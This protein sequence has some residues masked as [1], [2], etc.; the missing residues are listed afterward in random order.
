[1]ELPRSASRKFEPVCPSQLPGVHRPD[2]PSLRRSCGGFLCLLARP[3]GQ[4]SSPRVQ[5]DVPHA[6][7]DLSALLGMEREHL[8]CHTTPLSWLGAK[9][10]AA[11]ATE[12]QRYDLALL[13]LR[14]FT[15]FLRTMELL[16]LRLSHV[17]LFPN[18]GTFVIAII[19]SRTSKGLQQPKILQFL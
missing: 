3:T 10:L 16:S 14:G 17:R 11:A 4:A 8:P 19:N 12:V 18:Q 7:S 2:L 13:V 15:F 1:M 5:L 6:L 9:A